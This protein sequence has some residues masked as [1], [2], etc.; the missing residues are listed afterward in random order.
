MKLE[1]DE[2]DFTLVMRTLGLARLDFE[3][4]MCDCRTTERERANCREKA[5]MI[6]TAENVIQGAWN[7]AA[8]KSIDEKING[9]YKNAKE[10]DA[11]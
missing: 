9:H 6:R 7:E 5:K 10:G 3:S 11:K 4:R 2:T 8:L 1:I